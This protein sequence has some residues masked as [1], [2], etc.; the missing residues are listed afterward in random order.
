MILIRYMPMSQLVPHDSLQ[1]LLRV[2][3]VQITQP[4]AFL[5]RI[6]IQK[7]NLPAALHIRQYRLLEMF[8]QKR[9]RGRWIVRSRVK[10]N[11]LAVVQLLVGAFLE[12]HD[13]I[14]VLIVSTDGRRRYVRE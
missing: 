12:E 1:H 3:A 4:V 13:L 11:A 14:R 9:R 5:T 7:R 8:V 2:L 6:V 10:L